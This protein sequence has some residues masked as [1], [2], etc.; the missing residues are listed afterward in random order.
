MDL[1]ISPYLQGNYAPVPNGF[2]ANWMPGLT[3]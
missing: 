1:G 3:L 2:H